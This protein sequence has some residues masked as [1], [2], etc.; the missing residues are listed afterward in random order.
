MPRSASYDDLLMDM[1]RDKERARA[2]LNAALCEHDPRIFPIALRNVT[3]AQAAYPSHLLRQIAFPRAHPA[4]LGV[5][6]H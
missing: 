2:Y 5:A 4:I 3:E 1:L 6:E